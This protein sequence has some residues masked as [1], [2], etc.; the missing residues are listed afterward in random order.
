MACQLCERSVRV[1]QGPGRVLVFS[2]V[3]EL[4]FKIL[5][6]VRGWPEVFR[7]DDGALVAQTPD[8]ADFLARFQEGHPWSLLEREGVQ[9]LFLPEGTAFSFRSSQE[10]R[11]LAQWRAVQDGEFLAGILDRGDLVTHFQP[12]WD[13]RAN[14]RLGWEC[15]TRGL[16]EGDLV[17]PGRLFDAARASGMTFP[18]DRLARQTALRTARSQGLPGHLF[19]NFLPT[20]IYDPVFCLRTTTQ[21][22]R[23]LDIDPSRIVFEVV[24]SE[25]VVDGAQLRK[26]ADYY[27]REGFKM[28]L[29]DVG[30]GYASLN[31]LVDLH[32]D[33]V[34][35]DIGIVR[36]LPTSPAKQAVFEALRSLCRDLDILLLAEGVETEAESVWV[37]D[38]GADL[39]QGFWWGRPEASPTT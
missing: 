7:A 25:R 34:K 13:L 33:V 23:D 3:T 10:V 36:D 19:I 1:P 38:H 26:I 37:R 32:P 2:P 20:A 24:E 9:V 6:V 5:D 35:V 18:L 16:E 28:A 8:F 27:R 14:E 31:T 21:L 12:I 22:A 39:A 15:L 30:S 4:Q 17:S 29:D 11:S